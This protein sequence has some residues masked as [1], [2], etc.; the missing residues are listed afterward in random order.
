MRKKGWRTEEGGRKRVRE[1]EEGITMVV[2]GRIG[3][4]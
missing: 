2:K 4:R 3:E 1:G